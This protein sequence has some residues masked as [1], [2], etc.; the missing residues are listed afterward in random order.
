[1]TPCNEIDRKCHDIGR[2]SLVRLGLAALVVFSRGTEIL[3]AKS[4]K[5]KQE[6]ATRLLFN[7]NSSKRWVYRGGCA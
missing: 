1:M 7:T 2:I 4:F 3:Q 5:K 6:T